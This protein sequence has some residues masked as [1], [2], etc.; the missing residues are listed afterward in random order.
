MLTSR[1]DNVNI[2]AFVYIDIANHINHGCFSYWY[3]T[4]RIGIEFGKVQ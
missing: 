4:F 3:Y 1:A 2:V